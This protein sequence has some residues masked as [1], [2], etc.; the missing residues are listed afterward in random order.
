VIEIRSA[1]VEDAAV[2][3]DL[4]TSVGLAHRPHEV[5]DELT[6]VLSRDPG[7][8]LVAQ[9]E[10]GVVGSVFGAFDGRRGWL[11]RLATRP[12][13]R[14]EGIAGALVA[15]LEK[16]LRDMGCRKINLHITPGNA[17]VVQFYQRHGYAEKELIFMEKYLP[18]SPGD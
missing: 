9:D 4:W 13:A 2:L 15:A 8:V 16:A 7:L 11:N 10:R 18:R 12:D 5:A 1:T 3:S 17:G 6:S 14:G